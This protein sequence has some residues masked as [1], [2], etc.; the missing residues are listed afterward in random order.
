MLFKFI[1]NGTLPCDVSIKKDGFIQFDKDGV[2]D[3]KEWAE[4]RLL[5]NTYWITDPEVSEEIEEE[6]ETPKKGKK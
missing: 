1:P 6:V 4:I 5:Q 3:A 2:Y